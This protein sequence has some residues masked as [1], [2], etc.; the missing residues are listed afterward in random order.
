[1]SLNRVGLWVAWV[2][3]VAWSCGF[4]GLLRG[5]VSFH[6]GLKIDKHR[7]PHHLIKTHK[8]T[9]PHRR[10]NSNFLQLW[11][12]GFVGLWVCGFVGLWVCGFVGLCDCLVLTAIWF[13]SFASVW[14]RHLPPLRFNLTRN[15]RSLL[16]QSERDACRHYDSTSM[17]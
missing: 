3:W 2:A 10:T 4:V 14:R 5:F 15:E 9:N 13:S 17:Q 11:V 8:P 7:N 16:A 6:V 1:M 12:C